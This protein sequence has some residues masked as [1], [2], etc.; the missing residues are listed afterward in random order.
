MKSDPKFKKYLEY[1]TLGGEIAVAFTFPMLLGYW[2][3][4]VFDSSPWLLLTG[5]L[6]GVLLLLSMFFRIARNLNK[7]D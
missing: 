2:L 7:P 4:S 1:L 3:D 5:I 6:I